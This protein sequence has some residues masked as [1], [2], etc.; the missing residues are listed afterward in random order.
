VDLQTI[1]SQRVLGEEI[2]SG[3]LLVSQYIQ[4]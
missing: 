4:S 2:S 3:M 1:F